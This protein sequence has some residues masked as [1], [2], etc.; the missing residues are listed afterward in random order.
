MEDWIKITDVKDSFTAQN[1]IAF[2]A[3]NE[4]EAMDINKTDSS[5]AGAF[6]NVQI[7][8]HKVNM[9]KA[10]ILIQTNNF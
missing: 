2:L 10:L 1:I 7:Y 5:Y 9:E 3:E 4:I 8:C 6:G